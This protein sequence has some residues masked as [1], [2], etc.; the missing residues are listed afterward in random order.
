MIS[1]AR[2]LILLYVAQPWQRVCRLFLCSPFCPYYS[3]TV[4][5]DHT[6]VNVP[7]YKALARRR[8]EWSPKPFTKPLV[9]FAETPQPTYPNTGG[10]P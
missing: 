5:Q 9:R 10:G 2:I 7:R 8:I 6:I 4:V 1:R 3:A